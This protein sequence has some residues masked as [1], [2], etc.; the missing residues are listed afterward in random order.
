MAEIQANCLYD[1]EGDADNGELTFRAGDILTIIRQDIGDGWWEGKDSSGQQGLIPETYVEILSIPEPA[2]PPPP[3]PVPTSA[4]SAPSLP[5]A[6][7]YSNGPHD[8]G[9]G[10]PGGGDSHLEP[11]ASYEEWDEDWDSDDGD[12]TTG[13]LSSSIG[14]DLQYQGGSGLSAPRREHKQ[15]SPTG[16]TSKY[17]TVRSSFNRFSHFAKSGGE[18]FMMGQVDTNVPDSDRIRIVE[19]VDGPVWQ[20]Q[21]SPYTCTLASPKKESKMKGLK[22]FIAY[23]LTPSFSQIQVSRRYKHFD[24]LHERLEAKFICV[25]IP[26]LPDKQVTGRYEEDFVQERMKFLQMW[27]NRMVRHPLISRSEVFL[28]FLTCTDDKKWK[29]GKRKAEKDEYQGFKFFLTLSPPPQEMDMRDVD[30]RM[31]VFCKF[32][33]GMTDNVKQVHSII[34]DYAKKQMGPFKREYTKIGTAFKQL[35]ATF[36]MDTHEASRQLTA[37]IDHTGDA[38]NDI[39]VMFER[40][41]PCD[42]Y[43]F[44]DSLHE[45]KGILQTYPD[46]LKMHEGTVGKA[47]E[48]VKL[49]EESKLTDDELRKVMAR[50]STISYGTLAEMN[51]FQAERTKDFKLM[52]QMYLQSQI[53]FYK[54]MTKKLE[55]ALAHYETIEIPS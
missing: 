23:Q 43:P 5:P 26:P 50:A 36:N 28:H 21:D 39:G 31:E 22:S 38:Y 41:P 17:G 6:G 52:M 47:K 27:I 1:F 7:G 18:S 13:A 14:Q 53:K 4:P 54:N 51:H 29:Q 40:Q 20:H 24:W 25:P 55:D 48:C 12:S 34:L 9:G 35:A 37:A 32:V 30:A 19:T 8:G 16:E 42:A 2:F 46:V 11:Q 49:K 3:P 33:M 45:Y 44:L 10:R 15:L